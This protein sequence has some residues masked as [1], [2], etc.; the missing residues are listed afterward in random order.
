MYTFMKKIYLFLLILLVSWKNYTDITCNFT[1]DIIMCII[2]NLDEIENKIY[3]ADIGYNY[4][5]FWHIEYDFFEYLREN[6]TTNL[7]FS[8][9]SFMDKY[10]NLINNI[11]MEANEIF[12]EYPVLKNDGY[13]YYIH[14]IIY[15]HIIIYENIYNGN[16]I[17]ENLAHNFEEIN[18]KNINKIKSMI[19]INDKYII[20]KK[21]NLILKHFKWPRRVP[22]IGIANQ[23]NRA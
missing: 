13:K 8:E 17:G 18:L 12:F 4:R 5:K 23:L 9:N 11:P 7:E 16:I 10:N 21:T 1:E 20:D 22:G 3:Y 6:I 14:F 15:L 2:E 19:N